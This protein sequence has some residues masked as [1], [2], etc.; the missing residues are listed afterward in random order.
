MTVEAGKAKTAV[1]D[2]RAYY[3]CS[4]TCRE[5]VENDPAAY[6]GPAAAERHAMEHHHDNGHQ[7]AR[8]AA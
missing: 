6:V 7:D 4:A 8:N 2:G 5:K 1:H 3:F